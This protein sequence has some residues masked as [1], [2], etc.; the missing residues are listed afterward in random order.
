MRFH[1]TTYNVAPTIGGTRLQAKPRRGPDYYSVIISVRSADK[2]GEKAILYNG[3]TRTLVG[4]FSMADGDKFP[5]V[6]V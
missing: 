3:E 2:V 6:E 4:V 5:D 1:G